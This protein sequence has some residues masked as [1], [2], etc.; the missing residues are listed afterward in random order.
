MKTTESFV[1]DSFRFHAIRCRLAAVVHRPRNQAPGDPH[2]FS[3]WRGKSQQAVGVVVVVAE[4]NQALMA[5]PVVPFEGQHVNASAEAI[6][7]NALEVFD[8]FVLR[9]V[10]FRIVPAFEEACWGQLLGVTH[11]Y[12]LC[13][14]SNRPY[15]VPDRYLGGLIENHQVEGWL[16]SIQV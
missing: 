8:R 6:V 5:A 15:G 10:I 3:E 7:Q 2:T 14:A 11:D 9:R 1:N 16:T 4:G 13:A 12:G